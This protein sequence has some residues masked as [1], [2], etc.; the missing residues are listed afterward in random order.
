VLLRTANIRAEAN[1]NTASLGWIEGFSKP[2]LH[3]ELAPSGD[4]REGRFVAFAGL[5]RPEKFFDTL[6]AAGV[7]L[8]DAIPFA[9]HHPY[10]ADDF[11]ALEV[12]AA[13]HGAKLIT[14]EKDA[15][16]LTPEQRQRVAVLPVVA[17]FDDDA[18][19]DALLEPIR[20]RMS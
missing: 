11:A 2:I 17:R 18:A 8:T 12:L 16:R 10:D 19:F 13:E 14:T 20:Q 1:D 7:E 15:A 5:A 6:G 9:D 3:A 4:R